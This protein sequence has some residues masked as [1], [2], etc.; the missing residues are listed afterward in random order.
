MLTLRFKELQL[1][2][3]KPQVW[4]REDNLREIVVT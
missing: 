1:S 2:V 4:L 3:E